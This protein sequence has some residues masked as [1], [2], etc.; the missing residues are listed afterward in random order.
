MIYIG[1]DPAFRRNGFA[2]AMIQDK[3]IS[4]IQFKGGFIDFYCWLVDDAPRPE[5]CI[6]CVE[7]SNLTNKSFDMRGS[8]LVVARKSRDVGKNQATSQYVVDILKEWGYR[9]ID[10]SP[11]NKGGKWSSISLERV[12]KSEGISQSEKRT[13]QDKRDA[14]KLALIAMKKPYLAR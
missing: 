11:K 5:K 10:M 3:T 4:Y 8:R 6:I 7:N 14:A 9:V 2:L 1:I 12:L 13:N